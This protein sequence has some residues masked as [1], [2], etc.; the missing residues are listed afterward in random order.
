MLFSFQNNDPPVRLGC[1]PAGI[2]PTRG[3]GEGRVSL[4]FFLNPI[5]AEA[6]AGGDRCG[7][8]RLWGWFIQFAMKAT[9]ALSQMGGNIPAGDSEG[10]KAASLF[11]G[12]R[13]IRANAKA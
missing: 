7:F 8:L 13:S 11:A 12:I 5:F 9:R 3:F 4:L 10:G 2:V 1:S 6:A